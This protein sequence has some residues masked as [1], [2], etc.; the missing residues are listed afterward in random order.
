MHERPPDISDFNKM[1]DIQG[2]TTCE[3]TMTTTFTVV[4]KKKTLHNYCSCQ[5]MQKENKRKSI[6]TNKK[7]THPKQKDC[8]LTLYNN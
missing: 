8:P 1:T 3:G 4:D 7:K 6:A 2:I 5:L